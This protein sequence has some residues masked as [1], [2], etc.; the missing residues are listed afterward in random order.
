MRRNEGVSD[1]DEHLCAGKWKRLACSRSWDYNFVRS[2]QPFISKTQLKPAKQ[3]RETVTLWRQGD[4]GRGCLSYLLSS[5]SVDSF[6]PLLAPI[7]W[8]Q[9]RRLPSWQFLVPVFTAPTTQKAD[10]PLK[11]S[12]EKR[13][14]PREGFDWPTSGLTMVK[15]DLVTVIDSPSKHHMIDTRVEQPPG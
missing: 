13:K 12:T 1:V 15:A 11:F 6:S 3:T 14:Y 2:L 9:D 7:F 8:T 4:L 5:I 10:L